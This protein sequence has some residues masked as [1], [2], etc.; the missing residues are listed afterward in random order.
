MAAPLHVVRHFSDRASFR[1]HSHS[2]AAHLLGAIFTT[3]AVHHRR[4]L[5]VAGSH[6]PITE[7]NCL[8]G[9]YSPHAI[10]GWSLCRVLLH[11]LRLKQL[12][13]WSGPFP[14]T[15]IQTDNLTLTPHGE[16]H[17]KKIT[18]SRE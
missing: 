16:A 13:H 8:E 7:E 1:T 12:Q 10:N 11:Q 5:S 15:D 14:L 3:S 18:T 17:D 6:A 9:L 2:S 4:L